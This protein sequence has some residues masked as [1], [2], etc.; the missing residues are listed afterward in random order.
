MHAR[1][2]YEVIRAAVDI[3]VDSDFLDYTERRIAENGSC[4]EVVM[5]L[6]RRGKKVLVMS[7]RHYPEGVYRLPSG[8]IR[9]IES[10]K[11]AFKREVWE[12]TGLTPPISDKIAVIVSNFRCGTKILT[13]TS[14]VVA[15][16]ESSGIPGPI[17]A[18]EHISDY[19]EVTASELLAIADHLRSLLGRWEGFGKFRATAHDIVA[20]Y[21]ESRLV[22]GTTS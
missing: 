11:E 3:E 1:Q 10:P 4:G 6:P 2:G 8:G 5:V 22:R 13:Y 9:V 17:D 14:H 12:E 7:K 16:S 20:E 15:G 21:M 18:S 19:R